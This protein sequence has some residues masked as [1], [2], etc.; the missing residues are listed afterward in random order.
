MFSDLFF[1]FM[2]F[3]EV[4]I[5]AGLVGYLVFESEVC[6]DRMP[7]PAKDI[8]FA[9]SPGPASGISWIR[10]P[11]WL[12]RILPLPVLK[13]FYRFRLS[14]Y[15]CFP[16]SDPMYKSDSLT[17]CQKD[18]ITP[19]FGEIL[20]CEIIRYVLYAQFFLC[21]VDKQILRWDCRISSFWRV[22]QVQFSVIDFLQH[23]I[24]ESYRIIYGNKIFCVD[25]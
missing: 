9:H 17:I 24:Y 4:K 11:V 22:G 10:N 19:Q 21:P 12:S 13:I 7:L 20:G 8:L 25:W 3:P 2:L 15:L 14:S 18:N 5:V 16:V 6:S 1:V 23:L